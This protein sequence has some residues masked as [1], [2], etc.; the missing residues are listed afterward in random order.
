MIRLNKYLSLCGVTSRR[1][2]DA[3]IAAGRVCVNDVVVNQVGTVIDEEGDS[4]TVD[5]ATV[6]PVRQQ[7]YIV[8]NKPP[9]VM[10]T[11]HDP[12]GRKT[13]TDYLAE[14]PSRVYPVGRLDYDTEG[15]LL[16]TND[17]DLAYRLAHPRFRVEKIY[18]VRVIGE[19]NSAAAGRIES[20]IA[21]EDGAIGRGKVHILGSHPDIS[22]VRI[23]LAEGRKRE[24]KQLCKA[25]GHPV[26]QLRRIQFAGI[27]ARGL[28]LGK[29]RYLTADEVNGLRNLVG[30]KTADGR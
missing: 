3:L 15:V 12:F 20:G 16:L 2:A 27:T 26:K 5:G 18:D 29:W 25:V 17:G 4:V 11:L 7:L 22:K 21:L 28:K 19:F 30:L 9:G 24:I 8:F 6:E 23:T 10:T 14:V 13:V 1:G